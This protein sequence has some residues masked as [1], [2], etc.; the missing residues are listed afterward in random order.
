VTPPKVKSRV[1]PEYTVIAQNARVTGTVL[2][3]A[4]VTK[5]GGVQITRAIRPLGYGL[6][7]SAAEALSQWKFEPARRMGEPVDVLLT[8]A[9]GFNLR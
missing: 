7:E 3:E 1:E 9:I 5:N 4:I 6:E 8:V 2:L